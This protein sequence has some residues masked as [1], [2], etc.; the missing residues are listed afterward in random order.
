MSLSLAK[1]QRHTLA[2]RARLSLA[3]SKRRTL[4]RSEIITAFAIPV[5]TALVVA[6]TTVAV[7]RL[8]EYNEVKSANQ[9]IEELTRETRRLNGD[10]LHLVEKEG[11]LS[12]RPISWQLDHLR[13][14]LAEAEKKD[15]TQQHSVDIMGINALGPIHQG[16]PI[17]SG[18]LQRGGR[19][20]VLL[21]DPESQAWRARGDQE[22]DSLNRIGAELLAQPPRFCGQSSFA[23]MR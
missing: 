7:N 20:R 11:H 16:K 9:K 5:L 13:Q 4:A 15:G 3:K 12:E 8:F 10:Y 18:L 1:S 23:S 2:R 14:H 17:L 21:L 22:H 19:L 6:G